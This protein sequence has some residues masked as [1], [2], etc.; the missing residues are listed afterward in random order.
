MGSTIENDFYASGT[1]TFRTI[2]LPSACILNANV[3]AGAAIAASKV[4]HRH[5]KHFHQDDSAASAIIPI[6]EVHGATGTIIGLKC[7]S[8]VVAI[9]AATVTIDLLKNGV[10]ILTSVLVLDS[11][12]TIRVLEAALIANAALVDGDWLDLSITAAAG[13]GTLPTDM[14]YEFIWD[15]DPA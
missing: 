8:V 7:G 4:V 1:W 5:I 6:H 15:E 14:L 12:N 13:G 3:G 9:G 2:V 10:S 11:A